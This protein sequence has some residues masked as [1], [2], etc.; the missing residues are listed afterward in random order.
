MAL[1]LALS[2]PVMAEHPGISPV[3]G[4]EKEKAVST[5][6]NVSHTKAMGVAIYQSIKSAKMNLMIEN[7]IEVPLKVTLTNE[8]NEVLHVEK[9]SKRV[10]KYWRKFD[11]ETMNDGLYT[12]EVSDGFTKVTKVFK[13]ETRKRE[14]KEPTR[15]VSLLE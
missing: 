2:A 7:Y 1:L 11:M 8:Q 13:L 6:P 9:V 10:K 12:F 3:P 4:D 15:F 5:S 14:V